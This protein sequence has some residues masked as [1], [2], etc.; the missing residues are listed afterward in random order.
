MNTDLDTREFFAELPILY[1]FISVACQ[2]EQNKKK[3][4]YAYIA[5]SSTPNGNKPRAVSIVFE[6]VSSRASFEEKK[7]KKKSLTTR[8]S[9]H[10]NEIAQMYYILLEIRIERGRSLYNYNS[11]Y[12]YVSLNTGY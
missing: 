11:V 7:K 1:R 6:P 12:I 8:N 5:F 3:E 10:K 2:T 9:Q 4:K